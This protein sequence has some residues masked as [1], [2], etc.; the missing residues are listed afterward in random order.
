MVQVLEVWHCLSLC[1]LIIKIIRGSGGSLRWL[2]GKGIWLWWPSTRSIDISWW[3]LLHWTLL[4]P[5]D[6][7]KA[8][9]SLYDDSQRKLLQPLRVMHGAVGDG[10]FLLTLTTKKAVK[11]DTKWLAGPSIKYENT[12]D[13]VPWTG[14]ERLHQI[15]LTSGLQ[16]YQWNRNGL[17]NTWRLSLG[18]P[19]TEKT[20]P[21]RQ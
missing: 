15:D 10:G 6:A 7:G 21:G 17:E 20:S 12:Q 3:P 18:H 16:S 19:L 5:W 2:T 8:L 9:I 14:K 4:H 13:I 11:K 1:M